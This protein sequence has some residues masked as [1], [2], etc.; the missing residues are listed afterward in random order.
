MKSYVVRGV[1]MAMQRDGWW[2]SSAAPAT[3]AI[4][5][6]GE[7][8][9]MRPLLLVALIAM[10]DVL[11]WN[12]AAGL[13]IAVFVIALAG[14][15][16]L[17]IDPALNMR[18][19][20]IAGMGTLLCVL[21]VVELVQP[22]SVLILCAG[23]SVVLAFVAGLRPDRLLMGAV[24]L[25][26][27][28]PVQN[29]R[30]VWH[31][32]TNAGSAKIEASAVRN[33]FIGWG[34]PVALG[35]VFFALFAGANPVLG[36]WAETLIPKSLPEPDV[37]RMFFWGFIAFIS[38]PCLIL[39]RLRERMRSTRQIV[40][41]QRSYAVL[42]AQ[43]ILRSLVIFNL[44]FAAQT[45]M[46]M[47]FLYGVGDLPEGMTYASYAHRGAYPLLATA[48]LAGLFALISR[49]FAK[50]APM[51][52]LLLLLWVA[53][54]LALVVASL[55][56]MDLYITSYGLTHWRIAAVIWMGLV[57]TGL[58][59]VWLQIWKDKANGWMLLRVGL[60]GSAVLYACAFTSFDRMIARYNLTHDVTQDR[61]YL[62]Q[63]D[64]AAFPEIQRLTGKSA[65]DYCYYHYRN[66]TYSAF[67]PQ[68]W[69]EWGFR[70]WRVRRS[71]ASMTSETSQP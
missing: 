35:V 57:G 44:M 36:T 18:K 13:S 58:G 66:P 12:V 49:P 71:L 51:V 25:W 63:L 70:N 69:R 52:R 7:T 15:A 14:A 65:L 50:D 62:C 21:P 43:S 16:A 48:L 19:L 33:M 54:T 45:L 3:K 1:P 24:R 2:L 40:R 39:F 67:E 4:K 42:N 22:L 64:E 6:A 46:D 31:C 32:T 61:T 59:V 34:V 9:W 27:I 56:R 60:L 68:D 38:W 17:V 30:D 41:N 47:Y 53:Q 5:H 28:A 26:W 20:R 29:I 11:L 23:L 8:V 37:A 10:A 55:I